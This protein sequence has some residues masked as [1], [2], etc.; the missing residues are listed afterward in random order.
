MATIASAIVDNSKLPMG[1][2][3]PKRRKLRVLK[4]CDRCG[5]E[6]G[7]SLCKTCRASAETTP[8]K[9]GMC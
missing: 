7:Q 2:P 1:E 5:K 4:R 3:V 6:N 8:V 9:H